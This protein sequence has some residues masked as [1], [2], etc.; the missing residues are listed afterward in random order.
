MTDGEGREYGVGHPEGYEC[1]VGA[2]GYDPQSKFAGASANAT[3]FEVSRYANAGMKKSGDCPACCWNGCWQRL[4][5]G[6]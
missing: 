6:W 2:E 4:G 5:R 1:S 3:T